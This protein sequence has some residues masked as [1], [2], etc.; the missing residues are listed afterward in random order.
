VVDLVRP[1]IGTRPD[2]DPGSAIDTLLGVY[3]GASV[4]SLIPVASNDDD[5]SGGGTHSRVLFTAD[6]GRQYHIAVDGLAGAT[7]DIALT[8]CSL[9]TTAPVIAG[10]TFRWT[11]SGPAGSAWVLLASSDLRS[12]T[13]VQTNVVQVGELDVRLQD[14]EPPTQKQRF[15]RA[16]FRP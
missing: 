14:P 8:I 12:W 2:Y 7:G 5:P 4:A 9:E 3:E 16:E 6:S 10:N 1:G 13:P 15:Y 11:A